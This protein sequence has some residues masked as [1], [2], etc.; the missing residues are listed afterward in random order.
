MRLRITDYHTNIVLIEKNGE[1]L[2][3]NEATSFESS[4]GSVTEKD[5]MTIKDIIDFAEAEYLTAHANSI[6]VRFE[7]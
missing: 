7:D 6:K 3:A 1:I 5:A 2:Y 4:D